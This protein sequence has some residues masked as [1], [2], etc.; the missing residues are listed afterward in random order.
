MHEAAWSYKRP[1]ANFKYD[2]KRDM[3]ELTDQAVR[4]RAFKRRPGDGFQG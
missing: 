3:A 2:F 1:L 4:A